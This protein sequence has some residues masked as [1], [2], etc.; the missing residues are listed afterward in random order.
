MATGHIVP[1]TNKNGSISYQLVVESERDPI[2]GER[3]RSYKTVHCS[4]KEAQA[5]LRKLIAEIE[6]GGIT[7]P[8]TMKLSD[9]LNRWLTTYLPNIEETTR[10]GY[11]T[12][13][14]CYIKPAIGGIL[15]KSLRTE[16]IQ[17]MINDMIEK[18]LSPKNIR[19]TF[20]NLNAAMKINI[21]LDIIQTLQAHN[22]VKAPIFID[23]RESITKLHDIG[24]Q[25]VSLVVSEQDKV[26]RVERS[27]KQEVVEQPTLFDEVV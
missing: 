5:K 13:I 7:A 2:T 6:N 10:T 20:N 11:K 25:T 27:G 15:I 19:D 26:L 4:K 17:Q 14:R 3:R 1:K 8:S 16:H 12:K 22:G 18:E 9:W 23:N 24:T 21:G